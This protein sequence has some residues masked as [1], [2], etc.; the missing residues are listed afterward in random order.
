MKILF[1]D[2]EPLILSAIQRSLFDTDWEIICAES[3]EE[4]LEILP[5]EKPDVIVSDMRMP[6][7]NGAELLEKV[8]ALYPDTVRIILSGQSDQKTA[9]Q[10][11]FV[12]HQWLD[13]PCNQEVLTDTLKRIDTALHELPSKDIKA[14]VGQASTLPSPPSTFIEIYKL[15]STGA[16]NTESVANIIEKDPALTAKMLQ[17]TNSAFFLRGSKI[18]NVND[19]IVRLGLDLVNRV[20]LLTESY[21]KTPGDNFLN[22]GEEQLHG[23]II[24]KLAAQIAP[25][26]LKEP[27][28]LAGLL[29]EIGKHVLIQAFPGEADEYMSILKQGYNSEL[30]VS[31]RKLFHTDHAQIGAY[32]LFLWGFPAPVV[33]GVLYHHNIPMLL[34]RGFGVSATIYIANMLAHELDPNPML[35]EHFKLQTQL[36]EWK[37]MANAL[38]ERENMND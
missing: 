12:A 27:A 13:K 34:Q 18:T 22:V 11:S 23:L 29:H 21:S 28:M 38:L 8:F 26:E 24:S 1:V 30:I 32:L 9:L 6:N 31:E 10:T 7:M 33:S 25:K 37:N 16:A 35:I 17:L 20:V 3:G 19:A 15:L 4:A 36:T 5:I 14:A 2:D